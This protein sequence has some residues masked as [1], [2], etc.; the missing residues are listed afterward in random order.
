MQQ[1]PV[2]VAS[3]SYDLSLDT[4]P[5]VSVESNELVSF[6]SVLGTITSFSQ[7]TNYLAYAKNPYVI[8]D[9]N[10]RYNLV[11][12][13]ADSMLF[14]IYLITDTNRFASYAAYN[15]SFTLGQLARGGDSTSFTDYNAF[16]LFDQRTAAGMGLVFLSS[17]AFQTIQNNTSII[18]SQATTEIWNTPHSGSITS[19]DYFNLRYAL[20]AFNSVK[21]ISDLNSQ[22]ITL[23]NPLLI[24]VGVTSTED[25]SSPV[26][27][28]DANYSPF[29]PLDLNDTMD[30]NCFAG[31]S[32]DILV[33]SILL[34]VL[35]PRTDL[36][37]TE[38]FNSQNAF[39]DY[40]V[41]DAN[42]NAGDYNCTFTAYDLADNNATTF[43]SFTTTDTS[44]PSILV[45][46]SPDS[47]AGIDPDMNVLITATVTEYS[48]LN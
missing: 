2:I 28:T 33:K 43:A 46:S 37:I 22:I 40:I 32:D 45:S 21:G 41:A 11:G 1:A 19:S 8:I 47:N 29:T 25:S 27:T 17:K 26:V 10:V 3:S 15:G 30:I 31:F 6:A 16:G 13:V 9:T 14:D 5:T 39:M 34:N 4:A 42:L 38:T 35:G 18:D 44:A 20:L 24:S 7:D 36:N 12:E 48:D 23:K